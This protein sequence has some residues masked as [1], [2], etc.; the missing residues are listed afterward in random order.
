MPIQGPLISPFLHRSAVSGISLS[1]LS[2]EA[3]VDILTRKGDY[4]DQRE[5]TPQEGG[6]S[7]CRAKYSFNCGDSV[8]TI[9]GYTRYNR[10]YRY[11]CRLLQLLTLCS[12]RRRASSARR[13]S[14]YAARSAP[15]NSN[16]EMWSPIIQLRRVRLLFTARPAWMDICLSTLRIPRTNSPKFRSL[17]GSLISFNSCIIYR[18]GFQ[19]YFN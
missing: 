13:F 5:Q 15:F 8:P 14:P 16:S 18:S 1:P 19:L 10:M 17:V 3:Q 9:P 6:L 4:R 7:G 12:V 2:S 11:N